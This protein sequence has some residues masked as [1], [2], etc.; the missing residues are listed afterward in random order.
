MSASENLL[1][2]HALESVFERLY[3]TLDGARFERRSD[4]IVAV[5]PAFPIPQFNG[6]WVAED[7]QAAVDALPR[8]IAEVEATGAR[9]WVQT[10]AG[11]D[12]TRQAALD[13]GLTHAELI[14]GMVMRPDEL[15]EA[16]ASFPIS[17]IADEDADETN[18]LLVRAFEAPKDLF[19]QFGESLRRIEEVS[20][21][22]GR[23]DGAIV[24]TAV[25]FTVEGVTGIF[26]VATPPEHRGRG[27]GSV[28][29]SR[30]LR[31]AFDA[32]S[33][34]AFLQT[35]EL[36]HGVYRR[37]GFRD[38]EEYLLLTRPFS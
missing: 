19:E 30:A 5:C 27:Y 9:A 1:A 37:L 34:L 18:D 24:S 29:T 15:V 13:L 4:L 23:V 22:V 3:A 38:G 7:S 17:L 12:R 14:P 36:G 6:V 25:G 16:R 20:W 11:H 35:S 26:N 21:Y 8:A 2:H 33:Q 32:G 31:D 28:L 10:R